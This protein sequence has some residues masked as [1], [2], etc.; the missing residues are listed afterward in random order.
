M[1]Y[2]KYIGI[3]YS[4]NGRDTTGI[5]CWGLACLFYK[6]EFDI[7]LPT[8]TEFY[9]GGQ[10]PSISNLIN[11]N[12]D[13]WIEI[14]NPT[15]GD[16]CLFN[17]YNEPH[18]VGI[19]L[20]NNQF[21]HSREGKDTA[22]ESLNSPQWKKRFA[23]FFKHS[24][25]SIEVVGAPHPLRTG[26]IR[27]WTV[28]GTTIED[29]VNFIH[30][31]YEIS[32]DLEPTLVIMVDGIP[33]AKD[34]WPTTVLECD[35]KITYKIRPGSGREGLRLIL[36]L[37][38]VLTAQW[39]AATLVPGASAAGATLGTKLAAAAVYTATAIAGGALIDRIAP[40][41]P[42]KGYPDPGTPETLNL[43]NGATNQ[44]NRFG[45]IPV[46]LGKIRYSAILGAVPYIETLDNTNIIHL[47]L[48]WGFGP[49][50]IEDIC[51]G[52]T[53]LN[54]AYYQDL[55]VNVPL[56]QTIHGT[57]NETA[58]QIAEF[59]RLYPSDVE[60]HSDVGGLLVNTVDDG[61]PWRTVTFEQQVDRID[62]T[63]SFPEGMRKIISSGKSAGKIEEAVAVIEFQYMEKDPVT[64]TWPTYW[65]NSPGY[66]IGRG[67]INTIGFTENIIA[68]SAIVT[69]IEDPLNGYSYA[70]ATNTYRTYLVCME[71]NGTIKLIPGAVSDTSTADPSQT[72]INKYYNS[73]TYNNLIGYDNTY[74]RIPAL[75]P[76]YKHIYTITLSS[77][78]GLINLISHLNSWSYTGL[79]LT[80]VNHEEVN[81]DVYP[82]V[83]YAGHT[84]INITGGLIWDNQNPFPT[85]S[86]PL[87]IFE[88]RTN[89]IPNTV[90]GDIGNAY[91]SL[92]ADHGIWGADGLSPF[93]SDPV[94][95]T[96]DPKD[97]G[98][99]N[100]QLAADDYGSVYIDNKN[101]LSVSRSGGTKL[102]SQNTY[103]N[104][105]THTLNLK[106]TNTGGAKSIAC[107]IT[108][109]VGS[110]VVPHAALNSI[111]SFGTGGFYSK[112]KDGF[113]YTKSFK[114]P[115][116]AHRRI[117]VRRLNDSTAEIVNEEGEIQARNYFSVSLYSATGFNTTVPPMY[118]L[119]RGNIART[120][121]TV[122]SS[123]KVNG[124]IDGI[125]AIVKTKCLDWDST[126]NKWVPGRA[127]NN[128]ASLFLYVLTHSANAY[129]VP[130]SQ[131]DLNSL[132]EWH[133]FCSTSTPL[134]P[135]LSFNS[136]ITSTSSLMDVLKD[137]C[138]AGLASPTLIDG[139]WGVT[140]DKP[141]DFVVQHFTPHNSWG[142][143]SNK[144]LPQMPHAFRI[145]YQDEEQAYQTKE[146][147]VYNYG[148]NSTNAT[149][150]EELQLPGVTNVEQ[151]RFLGKWH[152]AQ[153]KLRPE[154]YK[155]NVDFEYLVC[156]RGDLVRVTHDVPLWG[157]GSSRIKSLVDTNNIRLTD[158]IL[159]TAG[160]SY[161]LSI[162][163]NYTNSTQDG[164]EYATLTN[165]TETKYYDEIQLTL[166]LS[167]NV[168]EDNLIIIDE[169][170]KETQELIV[171]KVEP[172]DNNS[173][174]LT[175]VDY[176]PQL[177]TTD[178]NSSLSHSSNI[179]KPGKAIINKGIYDT[180]IYV[181]LISDRYTAIKGS[182]NI[183]QSTAI[184]TFSNPTS[185]IASAT[186]VELQI[187]T[188][189]EIF[190]NTTKSLFTQKNSGSYTFTNLTPFEMYKIRF[191]YCNNSVSVFGPWSEIYTFTAAVGGNQPPTVQN[192]ILDLE[193]TYITAYVEQ[194]TD[195]IPDF[196][197]YEFRLYKDTGTEDF[198]DLVP[199]SINNI[200]IEQTT[201]I[202]RFN[203][204]QI[205][206]PRISDQGITYRV[207]CRVL[208]T[209]DEYS[210]ES[211]LGTIVIKTIQ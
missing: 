54:Q 146:E 101:V 135:V 183:F 55:P 32:E 13:N 71:A 152:F 99:F 158:S 9:S 57:G 35:Q 90:N 211:A 144:I 179:T 20:G 205:P 119:P 103:L 37:A 85:A 166:P 98:M 92:L 112:V 68:P 105:G 130:F 76:S 104:A 118:S 79:V 176:S 139:K 153:I 50:D 162:R 82:G 180:P 123:D 177:Y 100:I 173:A 24:D 124:Q 95:F 66:V 114:F 1:K 116:L 170:T 156:T 129:P 209:S 4:E 201:S 164:I 56:P 160:K 181:D 196:K 7:D 155:L 63:L 25:Q 94:T 11:T 49:L 143:Q 31:K 115:S 14:K 128:P 87:T 165:I 121:L 113:N 138:A 18:H 120:A 191:R 61:N 202:A 29:F 27:E 84:T 78:N 21:L 171:L 22:I 40:I 69:M 33:I 6:Q 17:I 74:S 10:D 41:R 43:L 52:S 42:D 194:N 175:L 131:I 111:V 77:N 39:A 26:I 70:Q 48:V 109:A 208:N 145:P 142:F 15:I 189:E 141:K 178:L 168:E 185:L 3:P 200:M 198:W 204:L 206:L 80:Y 106:G 172:S 159:L 133:N 34:K 197:T 151:V 12:I 51:V 8:Y 193:S 161:R 83:Q 30:K 149:V 16:L 96:V 174:A 75:P 46:V 28:A 195:L 150:F 47:L 81:S 117:R 107:R 132:Q 59:N 188:S 58:T 97:A 127:T 91:N 5:D 136:V 140:I 192:V 187:V 137:I 73:T 45:A 64:D 2:N 182:S 19:Y 134:R 72:F 125:N 186:R 60:Q 154:E 53:Q 36:T 67:D 167:S 147:Y 199:D 38:V 210:T 126:L 88:T 65:E 169:T 110:A 148:Y 108:S 93:I 44:I 23:G 122:Q 184:L 163:T 190:T 157:I 203:L 102:A 89:T 207:A 86:T 62:I